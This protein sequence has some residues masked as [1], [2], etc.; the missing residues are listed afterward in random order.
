MA[1]QIEFGKQAEKDFDKLDSVIQN[2]IMDFLD[3]LEQSDNPRQQGKALTGRH[4]GEWR[5]R[6]GDYRLICNI[7][8][9]KLFI[10]VLEIGHRS[11]VYKK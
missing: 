3:V 6:V 11:S 10:L 5:Y 9:K 8:D 1:W 4:K 2:R 7:Q